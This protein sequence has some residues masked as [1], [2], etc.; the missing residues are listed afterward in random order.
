MELTHLLDTSVLIDS[1]G[2]QLDERARVG[3]SVVCVGELQAGVLIARAADL[4][5]QRLQRLTAV[6]T[7]LP[8]IGVDAR[9]ASSYGALRAASGRAPANDLWIAATAI[10]HDLT[11]VTRDEHLSRLPGVMSALV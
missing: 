7:T 10:A 8:V 9:V 3:T 5:A 4:R 6:T 2:L 11:L 1:A